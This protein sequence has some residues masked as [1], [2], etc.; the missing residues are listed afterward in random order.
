MTLYSQAAEELKVNLVTF[1][2]KTCW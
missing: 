1:L 2:L